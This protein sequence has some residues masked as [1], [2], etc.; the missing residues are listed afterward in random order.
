LARVSGKSPLEYLDDAQ[1]TRQRAALRALL[2]DPPQ[3]ISTLADRFLSELQR[4]E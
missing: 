3:T 2:P 4:I 1:R